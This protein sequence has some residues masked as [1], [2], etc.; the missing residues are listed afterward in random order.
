MMLSFFLAMNKR[1]DTSFFRR[2]VLD[3]APDLLGKFLVRKLSDGTIIRSIIT[4]T[5]AYRGEDDLACHASKG[6]TKRTEIM[7]HDGGYIYIYLIYGMYWMLNFVTASNEIPQ[8]VLIR[9]IEHYNGPGKLT[10]A[11]DI[12]KSLH[13]LYLS[14]CENL[15]CEY[16]PIKFQIQKSKRVGIDYSGEIWKNKLWRFQIDLSNINRY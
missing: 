4:E 6:R 15:W 1:L 14:D 10:R 8:A 9:G 11:L 3:V 7:Y 12:N 5:E 13:G 2:D 16:N